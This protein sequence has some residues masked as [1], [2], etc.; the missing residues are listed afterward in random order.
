MTVSDA[1]QVA[2]SGDAVTIDPRADLAR[3]PPTA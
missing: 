3:A 2:I 1:A